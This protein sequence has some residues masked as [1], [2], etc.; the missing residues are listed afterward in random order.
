VVGVSFWP[1]WGPA[2]GPRHKLTRKGA[3]KVPAAA[4]S[5]KRRPG[6]RLTASNRSPPS[7]RRGKGA[8]GQS[9]RGKAGQHQGQHQGQHPPAPGRVHTR[10]LICWDTALIHTRRAP[11][12]AKPERAACANQAAAGDRASAC[13]DGAARQGSNDQPIETISRFKRPVNLRRASSSKPPLRGRQV[14]PARRPSP[15]G[16]GPTGRLAAR[17]PPVYTCPFPTPAGAP[18]SSITRYALSASSNAASSETTPRW[19]I[20]AWWRTSR[21]TW[22]LRG[23]RGGGE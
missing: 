16:G 8:R 23:R 6:A 1:C 11:L 12:Q 19:A 10:P 13:R 5:S 15:Y 14:G 21:S 17:S 2:R 7:A 22:K 4:G 20:I 18:A 3:R 9:P